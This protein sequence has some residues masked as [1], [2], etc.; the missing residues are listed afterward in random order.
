MQVL[1]SDTSCLIDLRKAALLEAFGQ[2]PYDLVIPDVL[3][4]EE[5]VQFTDAEK[6]FIAANFRILSLPGNQVE[7][8]RQVKRQNQ[9]LTLND[10]FAFVLAQQFTDCILLTGDNRLRRLATEAGIE[11]HGV[12]WAIDVM[13]S[14]DVTTVDRLYAALL[15]FRNDTTVRLP[16]P[17]LQR[18]IDRYSGL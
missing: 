11:V 17:D 2:V 5:L 14:A 12:L 13:Y 16:E 9:A 8:V 4:A 10:C 3:Y 15:I 7:Q 18:W 1:I 6:A